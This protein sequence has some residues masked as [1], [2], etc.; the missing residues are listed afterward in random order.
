M[1]DTVAVA[2]RSGLCIGFC[3]LLLKTVAVQSWPEKTGYRVD[4]VG[5]AL[6]QSVV[7]CHAVQ[8][9]RR[10]QFKSLAVKGLWEN[11]AELFYIQ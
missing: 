9:D 7:I 3:F 6:G 2:Q 4:S 5:T 1:L 8:L 11:V 10:S